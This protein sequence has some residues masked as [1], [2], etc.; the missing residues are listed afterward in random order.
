MAS[1]R[2]ALPSR[3][4]LKTAPATAVEVEE[5][6][7]TQ[8]FGEAPRASCRHRRRRHGAVWVAAP[9]CVSVPLLAAACAADDLRAAV[10]AKKCV[11]SWMEEFEV[12]PRACVGRVCAA[13]V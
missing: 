8:L 1:K 6:V 10:S 7:H 2:G 4:K 5:D 3:K 11:A 12:R 9:L 13:C